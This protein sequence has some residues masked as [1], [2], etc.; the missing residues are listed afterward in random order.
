MSYTD[1]NTFV[2]VPGS[3]PYAGNPGAD[4]SLPNGASLPGAT[5]SM[6]GAVLIPLGIGVGGLA[7]L[8][9]LFRREG[10]ALPP[11]RVDAANAINVYLS[12][13]LIQTP[14]KLM[15]YKYHGHKVAQAVLLVS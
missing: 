12:W 1:S 5:I 6:T 15:A 14:I 3:G 2:S 13:L 4:S 8:Y 10:G 11:L 9:H 7:V